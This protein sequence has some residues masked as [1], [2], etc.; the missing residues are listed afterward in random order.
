MA[1]ERM[2]KMSLSEKLG[3]RKGDLKNFVKYIADDPKQACKDFI[4]GK[5]HERRNLGDL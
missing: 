4:Y 3:Y 1:E 5:E 2:T